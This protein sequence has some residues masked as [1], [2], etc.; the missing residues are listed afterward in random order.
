MDKDLERRI[1]RAKELLAT[2]KHAAIATVNEDGSPHNTPVYF[3]YD[4]KLEYFYWGSHP[5]SIHS[6]NILR[7]G[8][9]F[10]VLYDAIKRGG[11]FIKG[12]DVHA[13]SGEELK[14]A[15][16]IHNLFRIKEGSEPLEISYYEGNNPQRMWKAK[17]TNFWVNYAEKDTNGHLAKDGRQEI[18]AKDLLS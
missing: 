13:V 5:E 15:L 6:L 18:T 9:I 14:E 2:S 7:T 11:L 1:V 4:S 10:I 12:E 3:M 16:N 8:K 17:M